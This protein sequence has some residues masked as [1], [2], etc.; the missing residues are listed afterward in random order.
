MCT[1]HGPG[2]GVVVAFRFWYCE[3]EEVDREEEEE[4]GTRRL[5]GVGSS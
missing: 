5:L 1:L 2:L 3:E 4:E